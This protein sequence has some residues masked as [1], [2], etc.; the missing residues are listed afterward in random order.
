MTVLAPVAE[1]CAGTNEWILHS[2][3]QDLPCLAE[4]GMHDRQRYATDL[5]GAWR[6]FDRVNWRPWSTL[7]GLGLIGPWRGRRS[8]A[9]ATLGWLGT[10]RW[11]WNLLIELHLRQSRGCWPKQGADWAAQEFESTCGRSGKGHQRPPAGPL[12][13]NLGILKCM[14]AGAG[15]GRRRRVTESPSAASPP[16]RVLPDSAAIIDAASRPKSVTTT[17]S[18]YRCSADAKKPARHRAAV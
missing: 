14:T 10:R 11:T 17:L 18:R 13:T 2:A 7:L 5:P 3:D 6:N 8:Q 16:R 9:P 1:R 4:V 12:A 15:H